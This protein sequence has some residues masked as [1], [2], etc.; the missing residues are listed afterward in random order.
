[1]KLK[2]SARCCVED[3]TMEEN[4]RLSPDLPEP[5]GEGPLALVGG[6]H[7]LSDHIDELRTWPGDI[8]AINQTAGW[9]Q[10]QGIDCYFFTVD[11]ST[12]THEFCSGEGVVHAHCN[13]LTFQGA[14]YKT[15]GSIPGPNTVVAGCFLGVK[16]GY[17]SIHIFGADSSYGETSHLYRNEPIDGLVE[18]ECGGDLYLTK[19]ELILQAERLAEVIRDLPEFF[20]N[21]SGGFL[22]ALVKHGDYDVTRVSRSIRDRMEFEK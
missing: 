13:P 8:W 17:R 6:G 10:E 16:A 14:V 19:L 4:V 11:P 20:E 21:R 22:S 2:I 15:T 1:M 3:S 7:S 12:R 9:C 18:V 5:Q